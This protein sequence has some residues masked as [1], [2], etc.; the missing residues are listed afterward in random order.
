MVEEYAPLRSICKFV[1]VLERSDV[2]NFDARPG[3]AINGYLYRT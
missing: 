1:D 3:Q 2:V